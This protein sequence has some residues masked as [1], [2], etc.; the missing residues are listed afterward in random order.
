MKYRSTI[1]ASPLCFMLMFIGA[2]CMA[3]TERQID[4]EVSRAIASIK[5]GKVGEARK[6]KD[7]LLH[8]SKTRFANRS[9]LFAPFYDLGKTYWQEDFYTE[10]LECIK[11]SITIGNRHFARD[12][13]D[14]ACSYEIMGHVYKELCDY[15]ASEKYFN[16]VLSI[17]ER[18]LG[19]QHL[20]VA[21]LHN[22]LANLYE[23]QTRYAESENAFKKA[24][25]IYEYNKE[26]LSAAD[27][28]Y[29][30]GLLYAQLGRLTDAETVHQRAMKIMRS[31]LPEDHLEMAYSF[32]ALGMV[33]NDMA[34]F[35]ESNELYRKAL[36]I[37]EAQLG[38]NHLRVA[39]VLNNLAASYNDQGR[40]DEAEPLY[41]R[42]IEIKKSRLPEDDPS[43]ATGYFNLANQYLDVGRQ[44]DAE[45]YY[46]RS[47]DILEQKLVS[48]HPELAQSLNSLANLYRS[49]GRYSEAELLY[50][51]SYRMFCESLGPEHT[52]SAM[53]LNNLALVKD[54]QGR[55]DEAEPLYIK[56]LEIRKKA[57]GDHP[58]TAQS[59][60]NLASLCSSLKRHKEAEEYFQE[61]LEIRKAT[62]GEQ[63]PDYAAALNNLAAVM[64][65]T[66]RLEQAEPLLS[67]S[68]EIH[69]KIYG[70]RHPELAAVLANFASLREKQNRFNEAETHYNRAV[71]IFENNVMA[72]DDGARWYY[73]RALLYKEQ[74]HGE[75][76]VS[77]LKRAMELSFE[78]RKH[79]SGTEGRRSQTF[80]KYMP[81]FERMVF[82]QHESGDMNEAYEAMEL[83]RAQGLN[84]LIDSHGIDFLEGLPE[85]VAAKLRGDEVA[86]QSTIKSL[87]KQ[88]AILP[89]RSDIKA[90]DKGKEEQRLQEALKESQKRLVDVWSTIK[91]AS[92]IYRTMIGGDRKPV[93]LDTVLSDLESDRSLAVEYMIGKTRSYSLVYGEKVKPV[94]HPIVLGEAQAELFGVEA[95]FLTSTKLDT[96]LQNKEQN[97]ILQIIGSKSGTHR[98]ALPDEATREKLA[99]L[100]EI[101]FPCPSLR[102]EIVTKSRFKRMLVLPD[103][104]LAKLP[105][106]TLIVEQDAVNPR[107]LLDRGP[108]IFYAPS[109]SMYYNL[110]HR[111]TS[112][113]SRT[114][115]TVGDPVYETNR[116]PQG[117]RWTG[118]SRFGRLDRLRWTGTETRWIEDVFKT[119]NYEVR[120]LDRNDSTESNVRKSVKDVA[121]VHLAC[122]GL[123]EDDH[124]NMFG[125]LALTVGDPDDPLDDG[126]LTLAEMFALDLKSCDLAILSACET[127]LGPNQRGEGTWSIGRGML[128]SGARR[129]V[130][131]NW[132]VADDASAY[133][134]YNFMKT[135]LDS[136]E[137]AVA[138][139]LRDA[140]L[141]IRNNR[142]HLHWR[143][144]YYWA[145]FVLIGP[146]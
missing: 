106:E 43:I 121:I 65:N 93:A 57:L 46:K 72:A 32:N 97:G 138:E 75:K 140:K 78:V 127:N 11:E 62:L 63:H 134:V 33:Y 53:L 38:K 83:S 50:Q 109:A 118:V 64:L 84:D 86:A 7:R 81:L 8:L 27:S 19:R 37:R 91:T 70:A 110:K 31:R 141:S 114:V 44:V 132:Q 103:A 98:N 66:N 74:D 85:D 99:S 3:Q 28:F 102:E 40:Y 9:T 137:S 26:P 42:S 143:H 52:N 76:A 61:T 120:R 115:L 125:C 41:L 117:N 13:V 30:L 58:V 123:A 88:L 146:N 71:S 89:V 136:Q 135:F 48:N 131:T 94:L 77:D 82:W 10:S 145:P 129:V 69:E 34:R 105:F 142:E 47:I 14:L 87:E 5:E 119:K 29:N 95:G 113:R 90:S 124:D 6:I 112:D 20:E 68:L 39:E 67:K 15:A 49:Q 111:K 96:I 116:S 1:I 133:I 79:V 122:H 80:V 107:Y 101:L 59:M 144:P 4:A 54:N 104:G 92:P 100:W 23:K 12:S 128:A 35:A 21:H 2:C 130:T 126:F 139:S 55:Y 18:K 25:R 60:N 16:L 51:R 108:V 22:S 36:K 73:K 56:A 24:I 17:R 45:A